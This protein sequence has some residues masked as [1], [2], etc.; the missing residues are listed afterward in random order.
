MGQFG[1]LPSVEELPPKKILIGY[2]RQAMRLNAAGIIPPA[3][4]R[5]RKPRPVVV[6]P[7]LKKALAQHAAARAMFEKFSPTHRREYCEWIAGAK[8][9]ETRARR[10]E[11]AIE[12]IAMGKPQNWKYQRR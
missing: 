2:V 7:V 8:R 5:P 4:A 9:E 6:P 11:K 10:L 3:R 12:W 1:R